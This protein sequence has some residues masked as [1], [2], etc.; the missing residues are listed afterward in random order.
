MGTRPAT[1]S[2]VTRGPFAGSPDPQ[3]GPPKAPQVCRGHSE[4]AR[5]FSAPRGPFFFLHSSASVGNI[6]EHALGATLFGGRGG[7]DDSYEEY[8]NMCLARDDAPN[9]VI[10]T[11][12]YII[13]IRGT[14]GWYALIITISRTRNARAILAEFRVH[15]RSTRARTFRHRK[16]REFY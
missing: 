8:V 7:R 6:R 9:N 11:Y 1:S 15:V 4:L 10:C 2:R 5:D 12:R 13:Y 16:A 3:R 14:H